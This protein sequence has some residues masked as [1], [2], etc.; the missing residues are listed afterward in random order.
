MMG[1]SYLVALGGHLQQYIL[2]MEGSTRVADIYNPLK[3]EAMLAHAEFQI[4]DEL[5]A[6][7]PDRGCLRGRILP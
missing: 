4:S 1:S 3:N 6:T 2:K 7:H 5:F